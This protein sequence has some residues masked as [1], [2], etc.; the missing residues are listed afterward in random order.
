MLLKDGAA[1]DQAVGEATAHQT[2]NRYGPWEREPGDGNLDKVPGPTGRS[3]CENLS[4]HESV[5]G[6]PRVLSAEDGFSL[7]LKGGGIRRGQ[8]WC[9][10]PR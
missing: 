2:F 4:M 3:R 5:N 7:L 10:P 1:T 6:L 8:V 9:Q